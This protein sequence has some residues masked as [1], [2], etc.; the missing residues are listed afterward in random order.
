MKTRKYLTTVHGLR[1]VKICLKNLS[2]HK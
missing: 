2:Q 1:A